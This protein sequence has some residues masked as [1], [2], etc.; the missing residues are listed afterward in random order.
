MSPNAIPNNTSLAK[1]TLKSIDEA[2]VL[3]WEHLFVPR[4]ESEGGRQKIVTWKCFL[5]L[6]LTIKKYAPKSIPEPPDL[7]CRHFLEAGA[8]SEGV[9]QKIQNMKVSLF[10]TTNK[11]FL[12]MDALNAMAEP[13]D[14]PW[15][16]L[17]EPGAG[18]EGGIQKSIT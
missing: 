13:P 6:F 9:S 15:R 12:S 5:I 4:P 14:L 16:H 2:P 8:E 18:F 7:A 11:T 3:V 1:D 10:T 17:F